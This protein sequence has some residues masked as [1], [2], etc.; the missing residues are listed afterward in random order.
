MCASRSRICAPARAGG[1]NAAANLDLA[2]QTADQRRGMLLVDR[3]RGK[4]A[5][6]RQARGAD[7]ACASSRPLRKWKY[8][9]AGCNGCPAAPCGHVDG[10]L[11]CPLLAARHLS[12]SPTGRASLRAVVRAAFSTVFPRARSPSNMKAPVGSAAPCRRGLLTTVGTPPA[13]PPPPPASAAS[14]STPTAP[15]RISSSSSPAAKPPSSQTLQGPPKADN[16]CAAE[17]DR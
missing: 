9:M 13:T 1:G 12:G 16:P 14:P 11:I 4:T 8:L 6:A 17:A 3:W 5:G 15:P 2:V 7:C 10:K